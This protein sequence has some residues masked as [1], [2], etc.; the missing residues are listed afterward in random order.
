ILTKNMPNKPL[1]KVEVLRKY[2]NNKMLKGIEDSDKVALNLTIDEAYQNLWFGDIFASYGLASANRYDVSG[3]LM[4]FSK[5]Y[6]NFLTTGLNNLGI[7][8]VGRSEEHTS[9]LQSRENLVCRLLLEKKNENQQLR[10]S[11]DTQV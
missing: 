11:I 1:D 2:S 10:I 6:K 8:R 4:N 3:N 5:K 7:N 9:E